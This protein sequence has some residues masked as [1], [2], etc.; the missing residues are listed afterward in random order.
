MLGWSAKTLADH[1]G[2]SLRTVQNLESSSGFDP[3]RRSSFLAV[4]AA[5]ESAG[6]EFI[7]NAEE[8]PGIRIWQPRRERTAT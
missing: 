6:I 3:N 1:S 7:G 4:K 5:L 8:G 2:L